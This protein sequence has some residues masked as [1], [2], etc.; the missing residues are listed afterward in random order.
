LAAA[1]GFGLYKGHCF[2]DGNKRLALATMDIFLRINGHPLTATEVDAALTML[3][4]ASD[5]MSE[6]DLTAWVKANSS[7][8]LDG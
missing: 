2:P 4:L 6:T 8:L 1:Y 5:Q 3:A 7:P